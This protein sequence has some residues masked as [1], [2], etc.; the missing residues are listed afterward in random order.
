MAEKKLKKIELERQEGELLDT[1]HLR[2]KVPKLAL[3]KE[4]SK[5]VRS[6]ESEMLLAARTV[7]DELAE[8][9]ARLG[10]KGLPTEDEEEKPTEQE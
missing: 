10:T 1:L 6:A 4:T 9:L 3:P 8:R 5:H 7:I 2:V